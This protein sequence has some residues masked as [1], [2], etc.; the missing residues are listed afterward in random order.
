MIKLWAHVQRN[1]PAE[2]N[3]NLRCSI[4]NPWVKHGLY[5]KYLEDYW[6]F[7]GEENEIDI[8]LDF[9]PND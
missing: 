3:R 1:R 9:S 7:P 2:Q 4:T 6:L 8:D 5:N